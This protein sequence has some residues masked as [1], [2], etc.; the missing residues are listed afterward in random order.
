MVVTEQPSS[1]SGRVPQLSSADPRLT[2]VTQRPLIATAHPPV[3][4]QTPTP[5]EIP[6]SSRALEQ[7][8]QTVARTPIADTS[9]Q[10]SEVVPPA[11][12]HGPTVDHSH[13][14]P[15]LLE[16]SELAALKALK[17]KERAALQDEGASINKRL[18]KAKSTPGIPVVVENIEAEHSIFLSK[19]RVLQQDIDNDENTR[20]NMV[21][22]LR[23]LLRQTPVSR[24]AL[25]LG[26]VD[27]NEKLVKLEAENQEMKAELRDL[28]ELV[29]QRRTG[30]PTD[31]QAQLSKLENSVNNQSMNNHGTSKRIRKLEEWK[32]G[33]QQGT[34]KPAPHEPELGP[35]QGPDLEL[36]RLDVKTAHGKAAEAQKK[37]DALEDRTLAL[38]REFQ[39][40]KE[41]L[42]EHSSW[43]QDRIEKLEGNY[44]SLWNNVNKLIREVP[45]VAESIQQV[46]KCLA[47]TDSLVAA[48]RSLEQRYS[49]INTEHLVKHMSQAM[50]ELFPSIPLVQ[51][52]IKSLE[53]Y[54]TGEIS[55]LKTA[56]QKPVD[57]ASL[58]SKINELRE[59]VT[60]KV[61]QIQT[62]M[63]GQTKSLAEQLE[64]T[65]EL[66][67]KFQTL[68]D[69]FSELG[70]S[71]PQAL[72][73]VE[74]VNGLFTRLE[75][76]SESTGKL[77]ANWEGQNVTE[78]VAELARL[79]ETLS[80][81]VNSLKTNQSA[82]E[83]VTKVNGI[84]EKLTV[85]TEKY[86]LLDAR[87]KQQETARWEEFDEL[88]ADHGSLLEEFHSMRTKFESQDR[89]EQMEKLSEELKNLSSDLSSLKTKFDEELGSLKARV[90]GSGHSE[91]L[92]R[93]KSEMLARIEKFQATVQ[94]GLDRTLATRYDAKNRPISNPRGVSALNGDH[95]RIL[96]SAT[97]NETERGHAQ[98]RSISH[99]ARD[100][101]TATTDSSGP[102][103]DAVSE[104]ENNTGDETD[105]SI[106]KK[107]PTAR[108][109][110]PMKY[111]IS[112]NENG[113]LVNQH[114]QY[115]AVSSD[116]D[117]KLS[118]QPASTEIPMAYR[119]TE[120]EN[121]HT[122]AG[123][124][125][126]RPPRET[127]LGGRL[128]SG[129]GSSSSLES[130]LSKKA[131]RK[132]EKKGKK[133]PR[134]KQKLSFPL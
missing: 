119:I 68:S 87:L 100:G 21:E 37:A 102:F 13:L 123:Q 82:Q 128:A 81:D 130:I 118:P 61:H 51:E 91:E 16:L 4:R 39:S 77:R 38:M 48:I 50:T 109:D 8:R 116:S 1:T 107:P 114:A 2:R 57:L 5:A 115:V 120:N 3:P 76:L 131:K 106:S 88:K 71:I 127:F 113:S 56:V 90:D 53:N 112:E 67:N 59:E 63:S 122:E 19:L 73:Q 80:V 94:S 34:L 47:V 99:P 93:L 132:R 42:N 15:V 111:G 95:Y 7:V 27:N 103:S 85:L 23:G 97:R 29:L 6:N 110:L 84:S 45:P 31:L 43:R 65:W 24:T 44:R 133:D 22:S 105:D 92:S 41:S 25:V 49:N 108:A 134:K 74:T 83:I 98:T 46:Q 101:P 35:S 125:R 78:T 66:K 52:Q 69:A 32:E 64:D 79:L 126:K 11:D 26:G 70:E 72:Q 96:G 104:N 10:S 75:E 30:I 33:V 129:T 117:D 18:E 40:V 20:Q 9:G 28:K 124:S 58:D 89:P 121:G 60:T 36:L 14:V 54:C 62:S 12:Q 55:A 17:E 86:Q